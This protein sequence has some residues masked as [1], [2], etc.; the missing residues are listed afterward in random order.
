M[1]LCTL[2]LA[3]CDYFFAEENIA[4]TEESITSKRLKAMGIG[5]YKYL[6]DIYDGQ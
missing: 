2:F 5:E 4:N 1:L 3:G 6:K